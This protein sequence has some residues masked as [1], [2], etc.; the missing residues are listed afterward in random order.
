MI[1]R[2]D[3]PAFDADDHLGEA[4]DASARLRR[5]GLPEESVAAIMGGDPARI[6]RVPA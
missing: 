5:R 2:L 1:R 6:L 3:L 4:Q